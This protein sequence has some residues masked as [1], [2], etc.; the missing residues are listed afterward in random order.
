M[1]TVAIAEQK[2]EVRRS[3][4]SLLVALW[5]ISPRRNAV[6]VVRQEQFRGSCPE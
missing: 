2:G 3:T 4:Q 6:F 1:I 5:L